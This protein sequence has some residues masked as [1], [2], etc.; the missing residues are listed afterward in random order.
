M[1]LLLAQFVLLARWA[2][3]LGELRDAGASLINTDRLKE[4]R[5]FLLGPVSS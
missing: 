3:D 5:G 4:L 1:L 2:D